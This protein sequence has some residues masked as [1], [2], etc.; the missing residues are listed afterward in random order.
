MQTSRYRHV[1]IKLTSILIT[2]SAIFHRGNAW[3]VALASGV[4]SSSYHISI[5]S[6]KGRRPYMEDEYILREDGKLLGVFDGHGGK[7][8]SEHLKNVIPN[9]FANL[10]EGKNTLTTDDVTHAFVKSLSKADEDV[11]KVRSWNRIGSTACLLSILPKEDGGRSFLTANI[12][13]SRAVLARD[14]KS[15]DLTVDH[16]PESPSEKCR[17]EKAGGTVEW[18]GMRTAT[19]QPILHSGVYRVNGNL[20]LS[21][22]IGTV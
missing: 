6:A 3:N 10:I 20:A 9:Y 18:V 19:G 12:G 13:D 15:I 21:R 22:A 2:T 17:I 11:V 7:L 5:A 8:V 4:P 16:K 14:G 1:S